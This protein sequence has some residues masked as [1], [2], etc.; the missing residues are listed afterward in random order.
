MI[1]TQ[2]AYKNLS[3]SCAIF[4]DLNRIMYMLIS[5]LTLYNAYTRFQKSHIKKPTNN[6]LL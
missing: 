2:Y 6:F 4:S 3:R 1:C 5:Y